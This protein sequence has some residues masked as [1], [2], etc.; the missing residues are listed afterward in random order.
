MLSISMRSIEH[1]KKYSQVLPAKA[2]VRDAGNGDWT[3]LRLVRNAKDLV[4]IMFRAHFRLLLLALLAF[5]K[6]ERLNIARIIR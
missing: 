6:A 5:D 3:I 1:R 2:S 4:E